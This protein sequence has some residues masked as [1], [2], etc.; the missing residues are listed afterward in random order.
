[1]PAAGYAAFLF[2]L[3]SQ[4]NVQLPSFPFIDKIGHFILYAGFGFF[5]ARAI[6]PFKHQRTLKKSILW[7]ITG[8]V[9]YGITDEFH[10]SFVPH[11]S[12]EAADVMA[13]MIGGIVGGVLLTLENH[14]KN[15]VRIQF[16]N[17]FQK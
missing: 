17:R 6:L 15:Y 8:A 12:V 1:M 13:D 16:E 9:L 4:S 11:R 2:Y 14:V 10:Q 3:S 5:F 7:A